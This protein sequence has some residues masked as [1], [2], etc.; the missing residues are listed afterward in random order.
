MQ[1]YTDRRN[2]QQGN[3]FSPNGQQYTGNQ[4]YQQYQPAYGTGQGSAGY[5]AFSQT[6]NSAAAG[7]GGAGYAAGYSQG[8]T[9]AYPQEYGQATPAGT[10]G[11][12]GYPSQGYGQ[13]YPQGYPKASGNG[14]QPFQG[15]LQSA[16]TG[17]QGFQGYPQS[18]GTGGQ[19]F[20]SYPQSAGAGS[21][22]F[23]GY[24]RQPAGGAPQY[25]YPGGYGIPQQQAPYTGQSYIPQTP[26][27]TG[28]G[29]PV[30]EQKGGYSPYGT[31]GRQNTGAGYPASGIPLNTSG[32]VP[33][34]VPVRK[35]NTGGTGDYVLLGVSV[36]LLALF[37]GGM[38][39]TGLG[40][41]KWVFLAAAVLSTTFLWIRPITANNKRMCFT[42]VFCALAAVT[43]F[44]MANPV[45]TGTTDRTGTAAGQTAAAVSKTPEPNA[46]SSGS[47]VI[48]SQSGQ[49]MDS[50]V[51]SEQNAEEP[52][53]G[54]IAVSR[55]RN[56]FQYWQANQTEEMVT[57]CLPSWRASVENPVVSLF[58][59]LANRKPVDEIE[60]ENITGTNNDTSRTITIVVLFSRNTGKEPAKYRMNI[61]VAYEENNWY[62]DPLSLKSNEKAETKD[63]RELET[64]TP[65]VEPTYGPNTVLYYNTD[66]GTKYHLDPECKS[67]HKKFLPF[68][69]HF[70][71][72][73]VNDPKYANLKPCNV[74]GAPLR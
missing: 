27:S 60:A 26:Y 6:G 33:P 38:F 43:V 51:P 53:Q 71:Y 68:K 42:I 9:P 72:A 66:G 48:D 62:V 47:G 59:L 24:P 5:Q 17:G 4:Q 2:S 40:M 39:A 3:S 16:G 52:D 56:F 7:Q 45:K 14:S 54:Q 21:Q 61:R 44:S 28:S 46:Q 70:T 22:G 18:A 1:G 58:Q 65:T 37:A 69:G 34:P 31:S 10:A 57:L 12:N 63:P 23:Q 8:Y 25:S 29:Y 11:Y 49:P 20:Q 36:L 67:T 32:Y 30:N 41:L 19:G 55:L 64:S 13:S 15:Y 50:A 74:C 35:R 73:E